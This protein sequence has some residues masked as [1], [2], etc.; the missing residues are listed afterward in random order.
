M[1]LIPF[2]LIIFS[3]G[4]FDKVDIINQSIEN[5]NVKVN[6]QLAG[7]LNLAI[8]SFLK[9]HFF[10]HGTQG[11][12]NLF[13]CFLLSIVFFVTFF[14]ILINKNILILDKNLKSK[15]FLFFFP[16]CLLFILAVDHG[17]T[18][19]IITLHLLFFLMILK[20]NNKRLSNFYKS[21][22]NNIFIR[23]CL[24][25]FLFFYIFMWFLPQG[26][27]YS[28]VGGFSSNAGILK[29]TLFNEIKNL[30]MIVYNFVDV[31]IYTLPKVII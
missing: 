30:F 17:R 1:T 14:Q 5:Y 9:W 26:G 29:N 18:L 24:M 22:L 8:G 3:P 10:Y 19:N 31:N 15:I 11:F 21:N 7:N 12:F 20:F 25:V 16:P 28:G 27:G 13:L 6:D 4:S 2:L 23:N